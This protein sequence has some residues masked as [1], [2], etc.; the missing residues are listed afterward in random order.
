MFLLY[1]SLAQRFERLLYRA[2]SNLVFKKQLNSA[3]RAPMPQHPSC[4]DCACSI[5]VLTT[6]DNTVRRKIARAGWST[7]ASSSIFAIR[8]LVRAIG[9]PQQ[10]LASL[11]EEQ[12]WHS[13]MLLLPVS[14][15]EHRLRGRIFAFQQWL[16]LSSV[17]CPNC[18]WI[19]KADD[20]THLDTLRMAPILKLLDKRLGSKSRALI[21]HIAWHTWNTI[22]FMHHSW[23][24]SFSRSTL[25]EAKR[26]IEFYSAPT[27]PAV[28]PKLKRALDRCKPGGVLTGCGWCPTEAECDGPFPFAVGWFFLLSRPLADELRD[29]D[30]VRREVSKRLPR[31]NRTWG[32]P[33]LEDIWLGS[34]LHRTSCRL[35]KGKQAQQDVA[36]LAPLTYVS[37]PPS[38]VFNGGWHTARGQEYNTSFIYHNKH[39]LPL[40]ASHVREKAKQM[41]KPSLQ[42]MGD[43]GPSKR[44]SLTKYASVQLRGFKRYLR[45]ASCGGEEERRWCALVED[46][47]LRGGEHHDNRHRINRIERQLTADERKSIDDYHQEVAKARRAFRLQLASGG[48]ANGEI[49]RADYE[50]M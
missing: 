10:T 9:L 7:A 24:S 15:A 50:Y 26:A 38:Y 2:V 35:R 17:I 23:F 6:P 45:E 11:D 13:D 3:R 31:V 28:D 27:P 40:I 22:Q 5:G 4:A 49:L 43:G 18:K 44:A 48:V 29:S 42:C 30:L 33:A 12:R 21:G 47:F 20:D 34:V 46:R 19:A 32:P 39:E 16:R 37:L 8:F 1:F 41:P 36:D 25:N 14:A